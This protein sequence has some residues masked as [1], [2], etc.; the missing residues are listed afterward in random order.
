MGCLI[1]RPLDLSTLLA[2]EKSELSM[3]RSLALM[4]KRIWFHK[5]MI[6]NVPNWGIVLLYQEYVLDIARYIDAWRQKLLVKQTDMGRLLTLTGLFDLRWF[7]QNIWAIKAIIHI[8]L[9]QTFRWSLTHALSILT[10]FDINVPENASEFNRG[11]REMNLS[12]FGS[13]PK[14]TVPWVDSW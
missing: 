9:K 6:E 13:I 5:K 2:R 12:C 3:R 7:P 1:R 11:V 14:V 10:R 8:S 4:E